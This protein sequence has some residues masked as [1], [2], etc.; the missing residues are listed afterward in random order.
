MG[1]GLI[2]PQAID[3]LLR[4]NID[5]AYLS[6]SG[7][8]RGRLQPPFPQ[9]LPLR[10][11]QYRLAEDKA[12]CLKFSRAIVAAKVKNSIY[13][14]TSKGQ[15][16][17]VGKQSEALKRVIDRIG[18]AG[19]V[20]KL[21]GLEGSA[22]AKYFKILPKLLKN[23]FGFTKRIKHPPTDPL[24][25]LLSLGYSLLFNY[26]HSMINLVGF[27]PYQGFFHKYKFGH[28]ALASDMMEELRAPVVDKLVV[29]MVNL[30]MIKERDFTKENGKTRM[31]KDAL[32]KYVTEFD[33]RLSAK[34]THANS[35]KSLDFKQIIEWQCRQ[36]ARVVLHKEPVYK[37]FIYGR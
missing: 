12:F 7:R 37:P 6:T 2:T 15:K 24:N 3:Y 18:R 1:N 34:Q 30:K 25:I 22:S 36:L 31:S 17:F 16:P 33:N 8:Y 29:R 11:A 13:L 35:G 10:K 32:K 28:A 26:V 20:N 5:V 4:K 19:D 27:D 9:N 14:A 23:D 21:L